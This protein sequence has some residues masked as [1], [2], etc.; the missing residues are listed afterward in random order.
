MS[1]AVIDF[2]NFTGETAAT[3]MEE[4]RNGKFFPWP[5]IMQILQKIR[6]LHESLPNVVEIPKPPPGKVIKVVGDTHGQFQDLLY[7]FDTFGPPSLENPYLFNGDYVDR[8]SQGIEILLTIFAWKIACPDSIF[9]N[10]GNQYV[11]LRR[12]I[13][14]LG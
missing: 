10:R 6:E 12:Y 5:V 14:R 1:E 4:L 9:M 8:G 13:M 2:D 7:I 11:Y 3:I